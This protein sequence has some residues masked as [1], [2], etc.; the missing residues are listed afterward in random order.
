MRVLG[1]L[2][3]AVL[4]CGLVWGQA[5]SVGAKVQAV[6]IV[7]ED[8]SGT[9]VEGA[10]V[11]ISPVPENLPAKMETD[12]K[13]ELALQLKPG[14]YELVGEMRGFRELPARID[15]K[16]SG[17]AQRFTIVLE[18][19]RESPNVVSAEIAKPGAGELQLSV[20]P[21]HKVYRITD[22]E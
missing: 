5:P 18:V 20:Y 11:R 3:V 4:A 8:P 17:T 21:F 12:A 22:E 2:V 10:H 19:S 7:V 14:G 15:V 9:V 1:N 13:G 6:V 16:E